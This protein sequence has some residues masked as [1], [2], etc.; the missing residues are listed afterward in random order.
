MGVYR[1]SSIIGLMAVLSLSAPL[2]YAEGEQEAEV[3]AAFAD[4]PAM[5]AIARCESKYTQFGKGGTALHGGYGGKMV[6]IF[7]IYS[8]IHAAYAK[9]RGMDIYTTEGNIAYARYLYQTEGTKPWLSSF[10]CWGNDVES[11]ERVEEAGA[12]TLAATATLSVNLSLGMEH[13]QVLTLQKI[14]NTN[15]FVLANDGPGSPG[16]ETNRYGALTRDAVRRFQCAQKIVCEG[17]EHSSGYGFVGARTRAALL[18]NITA[19]PQSKPDPVQPAT[20]SSPSSDDEIGRLQA[21]IAE[22]TRVL[23]GLLAARGS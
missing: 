21:Q 22:L 15:G 2:A 23:N 13:P 20:S 9:S 10:P 7:Q 3:R 4:A 19:A 6:G 17:D 8:D 16:N 1:V 18:G 5:I 14:L 12:A 11:A